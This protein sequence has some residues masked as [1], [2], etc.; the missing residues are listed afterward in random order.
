MIYHTKPNK[1]KGNLVTFYSFLSVA[2]TSFWQKDVSSIEVM[3]NSFTGE[4]NLSYVESWIESLTPRDSYILRDA[5]EQFS[6]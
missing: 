6:V 5:F 2:Y 1:N 4:C 3:E